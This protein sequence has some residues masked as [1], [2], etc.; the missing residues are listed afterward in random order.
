MYFRE[1]EF[2]CRCNKCI[3]RDAD[4]AL[5]ARL[6]AM[7]SDLGRPIYVVSGVRCPAQN[8]RVG[9]VDGSSHLDGTAAD[10]L[11]ASNGERND[12]LRAALKFF[13]R[14]G[15][16]KTFLHVDVDINKP[17]GVIWLYA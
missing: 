15:I 1:Q 2:W 8:E 14:V 7:R 4:P 6:N 16:G 10:L 3:P 17:Q 5:V 9:G 13:T 11:C 12:M